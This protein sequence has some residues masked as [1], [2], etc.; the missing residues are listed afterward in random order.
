MTRQSADGPHDGPVALHA[1]V[2][3]AANDAGCGSLESFPHARPKDYADARDTKYDSETKETVPVTFAAGDVIP[4]ECVRGYTIDGAK[5]GAVEF[6]VTC[7]EHGYYKPS[8]VCLKA[9]KCGKLPHIPHATPTGKT[10]GNKVEFA[11]SSG[12]SL[13]GEKVLEGGFGKNRFFELKCVEFTGSYDEFTGECKPYAFVPSTETIRI[14]NQVT[15]ALF[16]V[17]CKN[18]LRNSFGASETGQAPSGLEKVCG[19]FSDAGVKGECN[20]LISGIKSDFESQ[21]KKRQEQ[22]EGK[23]W[24]ELE[25][26]DLPGIGEEAQAFCVEL[27]GLLQ[28]PTEDA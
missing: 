15:E 24:E 10:D 14:Y 1:K 7:D 11:C 8:G 13:D 26:E 3:S 17:S 12:Y 20:G 19:K 23:D 2:S 21:W 18:R 27:W 25:K 22:S 6:D 16:I 28:M 5:D 9:S 4:F